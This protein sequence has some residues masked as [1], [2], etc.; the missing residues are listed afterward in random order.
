MGEAIYS[1]YEMRVRAVRAVQSGMSMADVSLAYQTNR[2]TIYRW[3]TRYEESGCEEG[4]IRKPVS[5]RPRAFGELDS[6]EILDVVLNPAS[7]YG[8]ETDFW[9]CVRLCDVFEQEY[10]T[11]ASRWTVWRM[12]REAGLTYQKPER[13]Y[14]EAS[15][16]ER[17]DWLRLELPK[18]RRTVK[19]HNAVLY[20]EDESNISLT[21]ILGKTWGLRGKTPVQE[22]TGNRAGFAAMSAVSRNGGLIFRLY[23]KRLASDEIIQFLE[24]MLAHH[25]RRHVVVV[26]DQAKP[27]TSK[28]TRTFYESQKRLHVFY[29]P[30][31]S[32]DW[33]PD[34][35][36]WNHLKHQELKGQKAKTKEELKTLAEEKL[37][38]M[39]GNPRQLQGIFF[40]CCV[41]E[42]LH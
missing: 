40:R 12:L 6:S 3:V 21:A 32:P 17:Q 11:S 15:E 33:N 9:T 10:G 38:Q 7:H 41:A 37:I 22:V 25:K 36:V 30:K 4:L 26:M 19:K 8:Y 34:E 1:T 14:F 27:H 5:G 42:L 28:K 16:E 23:D 31:Y 18:I 13:R 2:S 35:K 39:A 29:L 20:F 24:Q